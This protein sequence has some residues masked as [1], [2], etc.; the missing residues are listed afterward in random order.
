MTYK[1]PEEAHLLMVLQ[2]KKSGS[3]LID[4]MTT[5]KASVAHM[6]AGISSEAGELH[7]T[8]KKYVFYD[9]EMDRDHVVEELGDLEWYLAGLRHD[10][11]ISRE[12]VLHANMEKLAKRYPNYE[13]SNQR[14]AER[15]DKQTLYPGAPFEAESPITPRHTPK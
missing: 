4:E 11:G 5:T 2:L 7:N 10:L 12:E 3:T 15:A 6:A 8:L 13:F 1:T 14:A 9:I